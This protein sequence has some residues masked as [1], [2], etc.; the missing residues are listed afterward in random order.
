MS[1][2]RGDR[3]EGGMDTA[4]LLA[5]TGCVSLLL[6]LIRGGRGREGGSGH[7]GHYLADKGC[8]SLMSLIR[9]GREGGRE[10][11]WVDNGSS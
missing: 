11:G 9:G 7:W 5:D 6:S 10:G 1:L 4:M 2:I 8:V 3:W